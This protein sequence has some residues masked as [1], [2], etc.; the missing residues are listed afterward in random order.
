MSLVV[1]ATR[2][3]VTIAMATIAVLLFGSVALSRLNVN[4]LPDLAH[5]ALTIRTELEGAAPAE[6]ENLITKPVEEALGIVKNVEEIRSVSRTGQS[7]VILEFGWGTDMDVASLEVREKLDAI[8]R[9]IL[10]EL[11]ADGRMTNVELARRVGISAPPCLR[12]MRTLE[13]AGYIR[14]TDG[15]EHFTVL[16]MGMSNDFETAIDCGA[17][18][19]RIGRALFGEPEAE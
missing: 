11:Q 18:V 12:R 5:P 6:I 9:K 19:V 15:G 14:A 16:S 2:R 4:L 3:R 13:D 1:L 8:D 17:N 7:D 10:T